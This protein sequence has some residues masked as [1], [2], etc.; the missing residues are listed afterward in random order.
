MQQ[1]RYTPENESIFD[2][3]IVEIITF[4]V[5]FIVVIIYNI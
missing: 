1:R 4:Y 3:K 5:Y 2:Q